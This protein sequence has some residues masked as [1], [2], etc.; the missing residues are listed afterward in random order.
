[1]P[2]IRAH[3]HFL[4]KMATKMTADMEDTQKTSK[5]KC[6]SALKMLVTHIVQND[7]SEIRELQQPLFMHATVVIVN[8]CDYEQAQPIYDQ[9]M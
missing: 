6:R 8:M 7:I 4:T 5:E 3:A 2:W 1:M 9:Y